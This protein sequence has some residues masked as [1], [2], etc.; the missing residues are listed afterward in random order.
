MIYVIENEE[1]E[2][3]QAASGDWCV[4]ID[5]GDEIKQYNIGDY[6]E[7]L[8]F[9]LSHYEAERVEEEYPEEE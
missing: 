4:Q 8:Q 7:A 6:T 5:N 2:V 9:I 3:Y 1:Y